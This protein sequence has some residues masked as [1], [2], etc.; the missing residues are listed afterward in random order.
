MREDELRAERDR[1]NT[2]RE[3]NRQLRE[4]DERRQKLIEDIKRHNSQLR[5]V[6]IGVA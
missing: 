5:E 2:E 6:S 1:I 3:R 4:R